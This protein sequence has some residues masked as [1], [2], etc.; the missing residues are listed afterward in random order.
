MANH[1]TLHARKKSWLQ[2]KLIILEPAN[3]QERCLYASYHLST[4]AQD[5]LRSQSIVKRVYTWNMIQRR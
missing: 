4:L 2:M 3:N 5:L 1:D